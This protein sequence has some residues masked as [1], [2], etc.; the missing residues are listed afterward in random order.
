[1]FWFGDT[2]DGVITCRLISI[3]V[4]DA[5]NYDLVGAPDSFSFADKDCPLV[6]D[7]GW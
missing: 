2:T 5:L 7:P 6:N 4:K 3:P 1:M